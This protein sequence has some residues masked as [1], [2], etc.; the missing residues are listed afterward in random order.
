MH[1]TTKNTV[2]LSIHIFHFQQCLCKH[3]TPSPLVI[4]NFISFALFFKNLYFVFWTFC[5]APGASLPCLILK[6]NNTN[7]RLRIEHLNL[8]KPISHCQKF[9]Y[10]DC[11]TPQNNL[12]IIYLSFRLLFFSFLLWTKTRGKPERP[13]HKKEKKEKGNSKRNIILLQLHAATIFSWSHFIIHHFKLH[14]IF[15]YLANNTA[16]WILFHCSVIIRGV[17]LLSGLI[18]KGVQKFSIF[19]LWIFLVFWLLLIFL[20]FLFLLLF[21]WSNW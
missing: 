20:W 18:I 9:E 16:S 8:I 12:H 13:K 17:L 10:I 2:I 19:L 6:R 1:Q 15:Q 4:F 5:F 21:G 14:M 3:A 7:H 11:T